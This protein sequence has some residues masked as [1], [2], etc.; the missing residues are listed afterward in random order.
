[1]NL[2][3]VVDECTGD[4]VADFLKEEGYDVY[5]VADESPQALDTEIIH[6]AYEQKRI[7]VTND[8][9][10]GDMVY[11]DQLPH[12]GVIL[13]RLSDS[14]ASTKIRVLTSVLEQYPDK[15]QDRFVVATERH[16]RIRS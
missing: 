10:F 4:A 13:L 7:V 6:F 15:L 3:F 11:R 8:K 14:L 16:I 5:V 9:D 1:M 2:K 12:A